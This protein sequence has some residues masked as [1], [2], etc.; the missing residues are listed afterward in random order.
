MFPNNFQLD[1][2]M[3]RHLVA[4][5]AELRFAE[6]IEAHAGNV[7]FLAGALFVGRSLHFEMILLGD[8][9]RNTATTDRTVNGREVVSGSMRRSPLTLP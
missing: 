9:F 2:W 1:A 4:R 3:D 7:N 5:H 8:H 6:L